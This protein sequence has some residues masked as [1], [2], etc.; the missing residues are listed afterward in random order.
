MVDPG[1]NLVTFV[2]YQLTFDSTKVKLA[3]DP[4]TLNSAVFSSVEGP[5]LTDNSIAQSVSIGSDPTKAIQK[6]TKIGTINFKAVGSTNNTPTTIMFSTLTQALSSGANDQAGQNV[7]SNTTPAAITIVGSGSAVPTFQPTIAGTAATFSLLLHGIGAAG[8]NP[9]P[10]GNSLSNKTPVH[11]QRDLQV[12]VLNTENEIVA[13][14]SAPV[15]FDSNGKFVGQMSLGSI[16][17]GNYIFKVKTDRYLRKIVPGIQQIK[18]NENNVMPDTQMVA[19][20]TNGD[21]FLNVLDYNGLLDCGYGELNP[22]PNADANSKFNSQACKVHTPAVNI[23]INDTGI[24][25]SSDYNLFLRELSVQN[26]D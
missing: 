2:K 25:D 1:T 13:S 23:D 8:D 3:N 22:L 21:N 9:N 11:P 5:V 18:A 24:I 4:V 15:T 12:Q 16:P 17:P 14:V 19:G 20:D 7:L 6:P 10:T 26:G